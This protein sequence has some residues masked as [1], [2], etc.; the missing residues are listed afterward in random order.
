[1]FALTLIKT[2]GSPIAP[3]HVA[4]AQGA[5]EGMSIP[6]DD[7]PPHWFKGHKAVRGWILDKPNDDQ[8]TALRA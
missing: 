8:V 3:A 7:R 2:D 6:V 5:L 4:L 1:M